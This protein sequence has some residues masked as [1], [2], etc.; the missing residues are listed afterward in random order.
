MSYTASDAKYH[1]DKAIENKLGSLPAKMDRALEILT[2]PE[3]FPALKEYLR[4]L[5]EEASDA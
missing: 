2:S 1:L 4:K 5:E 3:V